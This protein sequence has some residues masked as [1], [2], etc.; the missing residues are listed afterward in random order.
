MQLFLVFP[1]LQGCKMARMHFHGPIYSTHIQLIPEAALNIYCV[2]GSRRS[3]LIDSGIAS[4]RDQIFGL[5]DEAK[6]SKE[7]LDYLLITH[8]HYDHIGCN[9]ALVEKFSPLVVS[10]PLARDWLEDYNKQYKEFCLFAP[11]IIPDDPEMRASVMDLMDGPV[12]LDLAVEEGF[13][14]HLGGEVALRAHHLPGHKHEELCWFERS[15]RTLILADAVIL[16]GLPFFQ[17]YMDVAAIKKTLKKLPRLVARL[18]AE[19]VAMAHY[20]AM[21]PDEF[22]ALT[23]KVAAHVEEIEMNCIKA[24]LSHPTGASTWEVCQE[25]CRA[26]KKQPEYHSLSTVMTHLDY[27]ADEGK[28][29]RVDKR[30]FTK[31]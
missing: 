17:G 27:L 24:V 1:Q 28:I 18:R 13:E 26:M 19:R 4:M 5:L 3:A 22:V 14:I 21:K 2:K 9:R 16:T 15:S 7:G 30:H 31:V 11:D 10:H 29:R 12:P 20:P 8:A 25:V 6:I 23:H